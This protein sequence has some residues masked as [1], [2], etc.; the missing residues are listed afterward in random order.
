M[1]QPD[2]HDAP[3]VPY[4]PNTSSRPIAPDGGSRPSPGRPLDRP[5]ATDHATN[6]T[7]CTEE[8]EPFV[9]DLS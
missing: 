5:P 4:T 2:T 9:P 1:Q 7:R 6:Y 8:I 3:L